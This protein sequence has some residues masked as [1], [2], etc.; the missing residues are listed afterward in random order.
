MEGMTSAECPCATRLPSSAQRG[1]LNISEVVL[2]AHHPNPEAGI[3]PWGL[4]PSLRFP[5][6]KSQWKIT[7][8]EGLV[9]PTSSPTQSRAGVL[10]SSCRSK[11]A[12]KRSLVLAIQDDPH[13]PFWGFGDL[14]G[15]QE[16]ARAG[17]C[18]SLILP[19]DTGHRQSC[20][21]LPARSAAARQP[22]IYR[23]L[24]LDDLH[25]F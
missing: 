22:D 18:R 2:A 17:Q 14:L 21:I 4:G 6:I 7:F 8:A 25:H 1:G 5:S 3:I 23:S 16:Q 11:A 20:S 24:F 15:S 19:Q 13:Q 12:Q 9:S 10:C